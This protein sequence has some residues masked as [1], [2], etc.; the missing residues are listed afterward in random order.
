VK[1]LLLFFILFY[2]LGC[3]SHLNKSKES[4]FIDCPRVFFSSENSVFASGENEEFD[5][6]KVNYKASLN[7]Y[8]FAGNCLSNQDNNQ[9]S[10]DVLMLV[11]PINPKNEKI[12]LPIFALIYDNKNTI[13]E[14]QYFRIED[15][16]EYDELNNFILTEVIG[17]LQILVNNET[18]V[19]S[20]TIGFVKIK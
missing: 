2:L 12:S 19:S 6:S 20:I 3:S 17:S 10:I 14:R 15:K 1:K 11:D 18:D 5:L 7:N 9:Y 4:T 13:I 8:G 16:I